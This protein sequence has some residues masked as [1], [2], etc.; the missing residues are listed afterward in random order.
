MNEAFI[1]SAQNHKIMKIIN[2]SKEKRANS[3]SVNLLIA[4]SDF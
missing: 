1:H 2:L 3:E 4:E